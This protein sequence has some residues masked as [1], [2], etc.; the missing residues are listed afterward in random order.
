MDFVVNGILGSQEIHRWFYSGSDMITI[1]V[2][3]DPDLD[4]SVTVR[5]P[6]GAD[7]ERKDSALA[8]GTEVISN[9]ELPD[10]GQY[11]ILVSDVSGHAGNYA[12]SITEPGSM[13]IIFPGNLNYGTRVSVTMPIDSFHIWHFL[14]NA[15]DSVTIEVAPNDDTDLI[16]SFFGPDMDNEID[17]IDFAIAGEAEVAT[18]ELAESGMYSIWVEEFS[19]ESSSYRVLVTR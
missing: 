10:A 2:A 16:F 9:V 11:Q 4:I 18:F 1:S 13:P 5:N 17:Y 3:G 15:G 7:I 19:G 8:G 12:I 6:A 14:G